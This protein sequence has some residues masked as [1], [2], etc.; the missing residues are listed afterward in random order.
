MAFAPLIPLDKVAENLLRSPGAREVTFQ[1]WMPIWWSKTDY[2]M[3]PP[4]H[5]TEWQ[6]F[7][8]QY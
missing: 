3:P 5:L 4:I 2:Q 7:G 6:F 8:A 1:E